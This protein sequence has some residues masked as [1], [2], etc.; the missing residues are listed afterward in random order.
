M[1]AAAAS[2]VAAAV[3]S[4]VAAAAALA[5]AVAT[6]VVSYWTEEAAAEDAMLLVTLESLKSWGSLA[7]AGAAFGS[8]ETDLLHESAGDKAVCQTGGAA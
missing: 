5:A 7:A 6:A 8:L 1:A 3:A 4:A 2:A